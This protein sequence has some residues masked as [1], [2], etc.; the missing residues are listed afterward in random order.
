MST[1][2]SYDFTEIVLKHLIRDKDVLTTAK[3]VGMTGEDMLTT[4]SAGIQ[5]YKVFADIAFEVNDSPIDPYLFLTLVKDKKSQGKLGASDADIGEL[6]SWIYQTELNSDYIKGQLNN[7]VLRR[8][9]SKKARAHDDDV[10]KLQEEFTK[11]NQDMRTAQV[12]G[13]VRR[14]T[15]FR[16][17]SKKPIHEGIM[18]G[19]A[20]V[21]EVLGGI[22]PGECALLVGHSGSGKTAVAT[23]IASGVVRT[24]RKVLYISCEEPMENINDRWY[25]NI[26]DMS[27]KHLHA[28]KAEFEKEQ[29]HRE[30]LEVDRLMMDNLRISDARELTPISKSQLIELI[31]LEAKDG[32]IADLVIIDQMDFLRPEKIMQKG[33]QKYQEYEQIAAELDQLSQYLILG[34]HPFAVLAIHQGTGDMKWCFGYN[35]IAGCKGI[36]KPF[37]WAL[38]VGRKHRN[39]P[40]INLFSMKVRHSEHFTCKYIADFDHMRF[41]DDPYGV[42]EDI[43]DDHDGSLQA[44]AKIAKAKENEKKK[45]EARDVK[46][47]SKRSTIFDQ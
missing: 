31:E 42:K 4:E 13:K 36:V 25:A 21:D 39:S 3:T 17:I 28:G 16:Q 27:Y 22:L 35:D 7:F 23:Y 10:V 5:I 19:L 38:G 37:D 1:Q 44:A 12:T 34:E 40:N 29:C 43:D 6:W 20:K 45:R 2:D 26:F 18:T 9:L 8:R 11:I 47:E 41:D 24:Y 15:P 30:M 14:S 33:V 46:V 32:F